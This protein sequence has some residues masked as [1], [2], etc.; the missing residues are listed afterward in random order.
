MFEDVAQLEQEY[1]G[2]FGSVTTTA[3]SGGG[4]KTD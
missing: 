4:T 2:F 1:A 3:T